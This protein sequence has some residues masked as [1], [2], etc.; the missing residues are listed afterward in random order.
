M[1]KLKKEIERR[2]QKEEQYLSEIKTLKEQATKV[3]L[4]LSNITK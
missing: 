1:S 2:D 4:R 3:E